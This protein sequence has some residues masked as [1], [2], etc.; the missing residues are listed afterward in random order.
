MTKYGMT[1][2]DP[3]HDS[4]MRSLAPES[5]GAGHVLYDWQTGREIW[6]LIHDEFG[7]SDWQRM[8][9]DFASLMAA[10]RIESGRWNIRACIP[11]TEQGAI[12]R[13]NRAECALIEA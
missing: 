10:Y 4:Y 9:P 7:V 12:I 3:V 8:Y 13:E 6:I 1:M 5:Q 11:N 2:I